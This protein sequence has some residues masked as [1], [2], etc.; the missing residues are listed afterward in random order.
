MR[1]LVL[2]AKFEIE[3]MS[4][5]VNFYT[6]RIYNILLYQLTRARLTCVL[7]FSG[8]FINRCVRF[9]GHVAENGEDYEPGKEACNAVDSTRRQRIPVSTKS[10]RNV[11]RETSS[12]R[13]S[14][15]IN[16]R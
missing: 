8:N 15:A 12:L 14:L 3:V 5:P 2:T 9:L 10:H 4:R 11:A 13:C 7:T 1:C 6:K 16:T